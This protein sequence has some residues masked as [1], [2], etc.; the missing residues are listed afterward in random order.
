[1]AKLNYN[2]EMKQPQEDGKELNVDNDKIS[3]LDQEFI[4]NGVKCGYNKN[5]CW[6]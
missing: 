6:R 3:Y 5:K 1:M 4:N 2:R